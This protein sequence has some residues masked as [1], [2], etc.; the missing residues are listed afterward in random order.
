MQT[1]LGAEERAS[2]ALVILTLAHSLLSLKDL[3]EL[4]R[5]A[6]SSYVSVLRA[7]LR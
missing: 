7:S 2:E 6:L 4:G 5:H 3:F 1:P